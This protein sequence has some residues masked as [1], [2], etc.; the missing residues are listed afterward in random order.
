MSNP[1]YDAVELDTADPG[2]GDEA[3]EAQQVRKKQDY[4]T[5]N[6]IMWSDLSTHTHTHTCTGDSSRCTL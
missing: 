6:E 3:S 4:E 1:V 2:Q 5:T